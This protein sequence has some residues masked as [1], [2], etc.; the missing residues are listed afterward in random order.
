MFGEVIANVMGN[1]RIY[2]AGVFFDRYK[3]ENDDGSVRELFGPWAFRRQGAFYAEDQA[4][5]SSMYID[6]DWFRQAK[7]RHGANFFGIKRYKLRAYVRSNPKGTSA[8]RHEFFPIIYR[9]APYEVGFWTKP[10]FRCDGKVDA[11]VMTYVS[12]FFGLDSLRTRL[13]FRGVTTVDVPLSFLELNQCPMPFSVPNAFKN[14]ARCD[15]LSTKCAPQAG[16]LFMRGSYM[17]TCRMGFEYWHSDGKFWI[18]GS[19]L[20]LE[21]EKKRAGIFSRFDHLTCRRGQASALYQGYVPIFL[22]VSVLV[23]LKVV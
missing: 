10:H 2:A 23:L 17:C 15:Y 11:W 13:E 12:P 6:S 20:E 8:V 19:L 14:T 16:F 9:A 22:S 18:E 3:F 21:Y 5:Y 4:G 7:A 1:Y